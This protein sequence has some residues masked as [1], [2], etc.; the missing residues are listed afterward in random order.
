MQKI[1]PACLLLLLSILLTTTANA[2]C[3]ILNEHFASAPT[4]A[5][6]PTDGAWYKDRYLPSAF[7]SSGGQL[8]ISIDGPNDGAQARPSAY[9]SAFYNT[10]GRKFNLCTSCNVTMAS[11][12]L[13][14]P[15]SWS[16]E[17]RR[18]D[19]W[20]TAYD[21]TNNISF[22]PI[23]G[24]RNVDGNSPSIDYWNGTGWTGS[25]VS[26]TYNTSYHLSFKLNGT[27]LEYYVNSNLVG[28]V[29]SGGSTYFGD[30][31]LQAYNFNDNTLSPSTM[32]DLSSSTNS[33][34]ALWDNIVATAA[35]GNVVTNSSSGLSFCTIGAAISD[36]N[37][38]N[39]NTLV[40]GAGTYNEALAVN[41]NLTI[42]G[43]NLGISGTGTRG[44]EAVL[45]DGSMNISANCTLD[46]FKI[47]QTNNTSDVLLL[48]GS[49]AANIQNNIFE[50][51]GIT[52]G[53]VV[54]A[55]TTA[56]GSGTKTIQNNLFT[57]DGSGGLFSGHKTWN[58]A[59]YING[60]S[61]TVNILNNTIQNS[62]T[63][64][65]LD[66]FN[67]GI[68]VSGNT[69]DNCGTMM[70]FGGV[71][72]TNGQY[73]MGSNNFKNPVDAIINLSN[74]DPAFRLDISSSKLN[75]AVFN[76]LPLATL[77][78][79]EAGMYHRLHSGKK[80]LVYYVANTEY[81][82]G[83]SGPSTIQDAVNYGASGD[84]INIKAGTYNE[85]VTINKP[86]TLKG[87]S[88]TTAIMDGTGL[89]GTGSGITINGNV[90]NVTIQDLM[91]E[92]YAGSS[93]NTHA[94]IRFGLGNDGIAIKNNIIK[95]NL[96]GA[97]IYGA[98]P[99]NGVLIDGNKVSGH[100]NVNGVAR[101][102]VIWDGLKENITI[103]N[104]E[105]FNNNC[106]GIEL[107]DGSATGVNISSNNVHDNGDNG[108][109]I[110]GMQGPGANVVSNNTVKDNGRFGIEIKNPNGS[111][112]TS[113]AGSIVVS[114]N[115]V[116]LTATPSDLRDYAGI[117]VF[118]RG[119]TGSNVDVPRGV[120]VS[121]NS[122]S[123]YVQSNS[124]SNSEG[125]GI[126]AEGIDHSIT[127][128]T[129]SGND[130]GIQRQAGHTPYP[131]D[132]DQSNLTDTYFGR[133]NSPMSCGITVSGNTV[134]SNTVNT[135]DVSYTGQGVVTNTNTSKE[136]CTIQA[137]INDA[138]TLATHVI[139]LSAGTYAEN[140]TV[141]K[142]VTIQGPNAT[143]SPCSGSRVAEA[144]VVPASSA[145]TSGKIFQI[146]AP[147]IT[148]KG[149]TIDGDNTNLSSGYLGT[150]GADL[151]AGYGIYMSKNNNN[152]IAVT[153]N[154]IQNVSIAG[155]SLD[156]T[157]GGASAMHSITNNKIR[158]LGTYDP[159]SGIDKR[160]YGI[161]LAFNQFANADNNCI[162][163]VRRGIQTNSFFRQKMS[164]TNPTIN[165]NTMTNVRRI[166]I[167]HNLFQVTA[168]PFEISNNSIT[169]VYNANEVAW[170]GINISSLIG[171]NATNTT[172]SNNTIDGGTAA[173]FASGY[174]VWNVKSIWA[175]TISG[176]TVTNVNK[177]V[178]LSNSDINWG[179]A[180]DGANASVSNLSI[181][182]TSGGTGIHLID[183][184]SSTHVG[185]NLTL[186]AGVTVTGGT[187]GVQI[188]NA[189]ASLTSL[190]NL[191][192]SGQSGDYVKLVNNSG[193]VD[194]T[195]ASFGGNTGNTA[196]NAQ[197]FAIEDKISHKID[198]ASLGF[199]NVKANNDF[200]T[201]NSFISPNTTP[202]IERG[203]SAVASGG[204]VNIGPGT[205]TESPTISKSVSIQ[206]VQAG[207]CAP[208]RSGTESIIN[209]TTGIGIY[210]NDVTLNGLTIQGQ[211]TQ[212]SPAWG[213]AVYMAPT[214]TGTHLINNIIQN[215]IIGSSL[216]NTGSNP[217][218]VLVDC[219][220]FQNNNN[221]G[222]ASGN[223]IYTDNS[224]SGGS[225]SNVMISNNKFSGNNN[226]GIV[227]DMV[228]NT[229]LGSNIYITSNTF[230]GNGNATVLHY[231]DNSSF[232]NNELTGQTATELYIGGGV[233]NFSIDNNKFDQSTTSTGAIKITDAFSGD[234]SNINV[235][236]NS[237][238][239]YSST[240]KA[241]NVTSGYPSGTVAATCNWFGSNSLPAATAQV[242]GPV[243]F[244][245]YLSA[246]TDGN[247][248][249]GF[250]PT[251]SCTGT[252]LLT[253]SS[254][255]SPNYPLAGQEI[256]TIYL[257]YPNCAQAEDITVATSGAVGTPIYTWEQNNCANVTSNVAN[258]TNTLH[259][260]P[261]TADTCS[262]NGDNIYTY[263]ATVTDAAGCQATTQQKLN[264]VN[265]YV[266]NI[267]NS[268]VL[269][270]HK[271][272]TRG[273]IVNQVLSLAPS[274]LAT[275]INHGDDLG[276]C[277]I[278]TG[279]QIV[280]QSEMQ[281]VAV[282]P[283]PTTGT[284]IVEIS[285][286]TEQADITISD[287]QGRTIAHKVLGQNEASTATFDLTNN[288]AGLYIVN[289]RDGEFSYVAKLILK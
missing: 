121:G 172:I 68:T 131:G 124:L 145:I 107:Q 25:G 150:N 224:V 60:A 192:L 44:A 222:S 13:Y 113:G 141:S 237:F 244:V 50:R 126:V 168:S 96:G 232:T 73:T 254:S 235:N 281:E 66:D 81:V 21:N 153:N 267:G 268:N 191:A 218:S 102:I 149:L 274:Q 45:A 130:V 128:N 248:A 259:F 216:S 215:N 260:A 104:N 202:S 91:I 92:N 87:E 193:N 200:V 183:N 176:G 250:Q 56:S 277:S 115:T 125:F 32:Q 57:G 117:A 270:C 99:V 79:V 223:G 97:G 127:G 238:L 284:F 2:Q 89:S 55:I 23:I 282:Y 171:D 273:R 31:I 47:L 27:N 119:L 163:N 83:G 167:F 109:G 220:L 98:G 256:H 90:H 72:P 93:P 142:S 82:I 10:Q 186:G 143:I 182:P 194:A 100:S 26:I 77:F 261:T 61:S 129:V 195:S 227:M 43:P 42:N 253:A 132:G 136:F 108:L 212:G 271:M 187:T 5:A 144:I 140:V 33:Y 146:T 139:E 53:N 199:V 78:Q 246:G 257:G 76:T 14:I 123:G 75:G 169:G 239:N 51:N 116:S 85:R 252:C 251:A 3:Y 19:I 242:S 217:S 170:D 148:I 54:R 152:N 36:A 265:P 174:Y 263:T 28:T 178:F 188:E 241:I 288:A 133:G 283:N 48:G 65:S 189:S 30:L 67:S 151:D 210:A 4:L 22:Y 9:S 214:Y 29:I 160:G 272:R 262:F 173:A 49:A 35:N 7:T 275:H 59:L 70:G 278:F 11:G 166:G 211:T 156:G 206:G 122:V 110:V 118:R 6:T 219:N 158:N 159:L 40:V 213:Y 258:N 243:T 39:G 177:G 197:N 207:V 196:T 80:G 84:L 181:T 16:T 287:I 120:V 286:I 190:N 111:G 106:C 64:L 58:N 285:K 289:V 74:V 162:D 229:T 103:T 245:P 161:L 24:F 184:P 101:G 63:G 208:T 15:S 209:C 154:I 204:T 105:V 37:T 46:G 179:N 269:V 69:F 137:A 221:P 230:S 180:G 17:H 249:T 198:L 34:D 203:V 228:S 71:S 95:D 38:V 18:S 226:S 280:A 8:K 135:R 236:E 112:A 155:V 147:N 264:V 94:G 205:F 165:G 175:P 231:V 185:V 233:T 138:T 86:L 134:S 62:R 255:V 164:G 201:V 240:N 225:M 247:V 52:T 157:G 41:K 276:N 1:K 88:N 12:D 279:K 114:G 234:N 20:A 266:G